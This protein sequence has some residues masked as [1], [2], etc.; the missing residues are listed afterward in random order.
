M[1]KKGKLIKDISANGLQVIVNQLIGLVLF[2]LTS[3]Y[4]LKEDFGYFNWAVALGSTIVAIASLGLDLIV[5]K[6]V[7]AAKDAASVVGIHLFHGLA[8]GFLAL[9]FVFLFYVFFLQSK[10]SINDLLFIAVFVYLVIG[11]VANSFKLCLTGLEA[12]KQLA[13]VLITA[14][15]LKLIAVLLLFV[16]GVFGIKSLILVYV[17]CSFAELLIARYMAN[18]HFE[19]PIW[20]KMQ[21]LNYKGL[22]VEALPQLGVV[23]FDSAL[24]RIDWILLG[25]IGTAVATA[26]YSFAY[27][28]FELSKLP[29][30]I[31]APILLTRFSKLFGGMDGPGAKVQQ[32]VQDYFKLE[33]VLVLMIPLV[34]VNVWTPLVDYLT[35]QKYGAVNAFTYSILALCIPLHA[36]INFLWTLAFVKGYLKSIMWITVLSSLVN[37]LANV[38][39]IPKYSSHGAAFAF[40]ISTVL[41]TVLYIVFTRD[42]AVSV[43]WTD[44]LLVL[45]FAVF[46][47]FIAKLLTEQVLLSAVLSVLIFVLLCVVGKQLQPAKIKML[48]LSKGE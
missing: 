5:V 22:V 24:A 25:L 6:R 12:Y 39:L 27:R 26:E 43:R 45:L 20:P 1:N 31:L 16:F 3:T 8:S 37:I 7:A 17:F 18:K 4:L 23:L 44:A 38:L 2:Y 35:H 19:K 10:D 11:N 32:D 48:L 21:W 40:L 41:Q 46:A 47:V 36:V 42:A 13:W 15:V 14:N 34:L 30:L 9:F 29:L 33:M 28:V